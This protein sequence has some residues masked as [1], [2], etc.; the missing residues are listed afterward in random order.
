ML[1][2]PVPSGNPDNIMAAW[3]GGAFDTKRSRLLVW[4]GGHSDYAGNELYAF[5]VAA[6]QWSRLSNPSSSPVSVHTYDQLEYAPDQDRFVGIG[7]AVWPTGNATN[8]VWLF[9]LANNAW[10]RG[11][12]IVG[13]LF[14]IYEYNMDTAYDPVSHKV[15]MVGYTASADYNPATD[16]WRDNLN[17]AS[18]RLDTTGA[19]DSKRRKFVFIGGGAASYFNVDSTGKMGDQQSLQTSGATE[20]QGC[21]A[22]GL[23][24]DPVADRIVGWCSGADVYSLN[25]DTNVWTKL[26]PTN[27]VSPGT[28]ASNGTFGRF[29]YMPAYNAY[30]VVNRTNANVFAYKLSNGAGVPSGPNVTFTASSSGV[31][32]GGT[33]TLTWSSNATQCQAS[34]GWT[35]AK[36]PSG[37]QDITSITATTTFVLA[38][39]DAQGTTTTR[40]VTV[41]LQVTALPTVNISANP[42]QVASGGASQITWSSS[43]ATGCTASGGISG[44]P[45][46]KATSGSQSVSPI[47]AATTFTLMCTGAGGNTQ[48]SAA[49]S[50]AAAPTLTLTAAPMTVTSGNK[51]TLTWSSSRATGCV[52]SDAWAGNKPMS[53]TE[54]SAALT[55]NSTFSMQC[56]GQGGAVTRSVA[57]AVTAAT[58][59]PPPPPPPTPDPPGSSSS[60]GGA[61]DTLLLMVL[62]LLAIVRGQR[63]FTNAARPGRTPRA[64]QVGTVLALLFLVCPSLSMADANSDWLARSTGPG[65]VYAN[66]LDDYNRDVLPNLWDAPGTVANAFDPNVRASGSGSLRFDFVPGGEGFGGELAISL[67]DDPAKQFGAGDEFWVQ[68]RQRWDAYVLEHHYAVTQGPGGWKQIIISQGQLPG[69][70]RTDTHSCSENQIFLANGG[71]KGYP[72]GAHGCFVYYGIVSV[73]PSNARSAMNLGDQIG[74]LSAPRREDTWPCT[75]F[76]DGGR[77]DGCIDYRP[78]QWMTLMIHVKAGPSGTAVSSISDGAGP[79]KGFINS[80]YELYLAY[81]GEAFRLAHRQDGIVLRVGNYADDPGNS[82]HQ[83]KY[84]MFRW[85]PHLSFKDPSEQHP[86]ASTWVDEII[87]SRNDIPAPGAPPVANPPPT[88]TLSA[89]PTTV[90]VGSSTTISW[91]SSNA[92]ACTG[93]AGISGWPGAKATSGSQSVGPI[94]AAATFTLS[95][96]GGGGSTQ[97][98]VSISLRPAPSVSISANPTSVSAGGQSTLTWSTSNADSC[99]ASGGWA[100]AKAVSGSEKSAA[101]QQSTTF[102]LSC[103]GGGGTTQKSATVSVSAGTSPPPSPPSPPPSPSPPPAPSPPGGGSGSSG[104]GGALGLMYLMSLAVCLGTRRLQQRK[105]QEIGR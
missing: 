87:I 91:T 101:L 18:R 51:T 24:Y 62:G 26:A 61:T 100:G 70:K 45:G 46:S 52:A 75:Y 44:W 15:L 74:N 102:T 14:Y 22:P 99:S 35:G 19:L 7:G 85:L 49:V 69:Q 1:P 104:G 59:P 38:C 53:G 92:T 89:S 80:T 5:D 39:S 47:T 13:A 68:W 54:Q 12:N 9:D 95:C 72:W 10:I 60:G 64:A 56:T 96:T 3:S 2:S 105:V 36:A 41:S 58:E 84:G 94:S 65:V 27:A 50:L 81:E 33:V 97:R 55:Q 11:A 71:Y 67:G 28:P 63:V 103:I 76:P 78:D 25:L 29:R 86:V 93:S 40:S 43:N 37:S 34:G 30:I 6:G 16:T 73:A 21:T 42:A 90:A 98:S 8:A 17:S 83:A 4:G 23:D 82:S 32:S 88:V 66:G 20:I 57:V 77:Q 48:K 31:I 79:E